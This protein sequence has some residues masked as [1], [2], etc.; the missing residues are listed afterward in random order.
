[1]FHAGRS[2]KNIS[3]E[4]NRLVHYYKSE[5]EVPEPK[6]FQNIPRDILPRILYHA[7]VKSLNSKTIDPLTKN[8]PRQYLL[9]KI[10]SNSTSLGSINS[11]LYEALRSLTGEDDLEK[12]LQEFKKIASNIT[13]FTSTGIKEIFPN[14]MNMHKEM[15]YSFFKYFLESFQSLKSIELNLDDLA[16]IIQKTGFSREYA[17]FIYEQIIEILF[18]NNP[19]IK[20]L[21]IFGYGN[22]GKI[23][24]RDY[25]QEQNVQHLSFFTQKL[26][27]LNKLNRINFLRCEYAD[28]D[29]FKLPCLQT[30]KKLE[31]WGP[32][33]EISLKNFESISQFK[34]LNKLSLNLSK[35]FRSDEDI[36][37]WLEAIRNLKNAPINT[38]GIQM[39]HGYPEVGKVLSKMHEALS[40]LKKLT[41]SHN[42]NDDCKYREYSPDVVY[43]QLIPNIAKFQS[44][45]EVDIFLTSYFDFSEDLELENLR[46]FQL[47]PSLKKLNI[48]LYKGLYQDRRQRFPISTDD[49]K[50]KLRHLLPNVALEVDLF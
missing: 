15:N 3:K 45:E 11:C 12:A 46:H 31:I 27:R 4:L 8:F 42:V 25:T 35:A 29:T 23:P 26:R 28:L 30:L 49:L 43:H 22:G 19:N 41:L 36:E 34:N 39:P 5:L 20:E 38:L 17:L 10:I 6:I 33:N 40:G 7:H 1:M 48:H 44:L 18:T 37:K 13:H 32:S 9:E 14:S 50:Q 47:C 24:I 16:E 21:S 2:G